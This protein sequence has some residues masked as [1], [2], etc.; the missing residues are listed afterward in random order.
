MVDLTMPGSREVSERFPASIRGA[1]SYYL[2]R[3]HLNVEHHDYLYWI[4]EQMRQESDKE[5]YFPTYNDVLKYALQM[6]CAK[7]GASER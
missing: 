6:A 5:D 4:A 2:D 1:G 3:V 7:L